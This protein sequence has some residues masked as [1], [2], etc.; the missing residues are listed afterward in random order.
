ME[1]TLGYTFFYKTDH[2]AHP[3]THVCTFTVVQKNK[4][5]NI[6]FCKH[7]KSVSNSKNVL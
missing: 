7:E 6:N 3:H 4:R 2:C 1:T 5:N